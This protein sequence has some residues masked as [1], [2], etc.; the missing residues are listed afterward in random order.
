MNAPLSTSIRYAAVAAA[1]VLAIVSG[2]AIPSADQV[3]K[4]TPVVVANDASSPVPTQLIGPVQVI[5]GVSFA[6][7]GEL[8]QF[9]KLVVMAP[10]SPALQVVDGYDVPD[11]KRLIVDHVTS[12]LLLGKDARMQIRVGVPGAMHFLQYQID[13]NSDASTVFDRVTAN[14]AMTF[15]VDDA[16]PDAG[17]LKIQ[18]LREGVP[19]SNAVAQVFTFTGRL[20]DLPQ[21]PQ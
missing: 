18:I 16:G 8:V 6:P 4:T 21:A 11:G 17:E 19:P 20:L 5:G 13:A 12:A 9:E 2:T 14:Q 3:P 7:A 15:F 1:A 10:D